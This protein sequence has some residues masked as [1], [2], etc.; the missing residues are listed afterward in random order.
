M[1]PEPGSRSDQRTVAFSLPASEE[2]TE[3]APFYEIVRNVADK[4]DLLIKEAQALYPEKASIFG[5]L[6]F[7]PI[8]A[9]VCFLEPRPESSN[10]ELVRSRFQF[11]H[12]L[13]GQFSQRF[14]NRTS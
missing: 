3:A 10:Q 12:S 4:V 1:P 9:F 7:D 8:S 5:F 2:R 11:L 6:I 14:P 13:P